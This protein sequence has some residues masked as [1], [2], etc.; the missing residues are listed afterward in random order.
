MESFCL[1]KTE[2]GLIIIYNSIAITESN[3][4]TGNNS[5]EIPLT[6]KAAVLGR[7]LGIILFGFHFKHKYQFKDTWLDFLPLNGSVCLDKTQTASMEHV[8]THQE[9]EALK[10]PNIW[11]FGTISTDSC[12]IQQHVEWSHF[13]EGRQKWHLEVDGIWKRQ[14]FHLRLILKCVKDETLR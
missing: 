4:G 13:T 1:L 11:S 5:L 14:W 9:I 2:R 12:N 6:T 10:Q 3:V 7:A 8:L